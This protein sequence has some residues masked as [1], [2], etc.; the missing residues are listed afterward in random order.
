MLLKSE[1]AIK[2]PLEA[3]RNCIAPPPLLSGDATTD[4]DTT[5]PAASI[6]LNLERALGLLVTAAQKRKPRVHSID[7]LIADLKDLEELPSPGDAGGGGASATAAKLADAAAARLADAEL[8]EAHAI[9]AAFCGA[10]RLARRGGAIAAQLAKTK[11]RLTKELD[12]WNALVL[13]LAQTVS[14]ARA[15]SGLLQALSADEHATAL[16]NILDEVAALL[17]KLTPTEGG[18]KHDLKHRLLGAL[19]GG[20][21]GDPEHRDYARGPLGL[22][23]TLAKE[24][25][26]DDVMYR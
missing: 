20:A 2:A 4:D 17:A 14:A 18:H 10:V 26:C 12:Q 16:A 13:G 6:P 8:R 22:L 24:V 25:G 15:S 23:T 7:E 19:D 3:F 21:L 5:T 1:D 11:T 9:V